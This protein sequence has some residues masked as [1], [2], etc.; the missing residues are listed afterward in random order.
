MK[1]QNNK[2]KIL[3]VGSIAIDTI[4]SVHGSINERIQIKNGKLLKQNLMF[5]ANE[6]KEFYGGTGGNIAYG[7]GLLGAKPLLFSVA[8]KDFPLVYEK[9]LKKN[10]VVSKVLVLKNHWT[11]NFYG[12]TDNKLEQ[13]GIWQPNAYEHLEQSSLLDTCSKKELGQVS[14]AI[15]SAGTPRSMFKHMIELKENAPSVTIIFD[16]GQLVMTYPKRVLETCL[17]LAS[18]IIVNEVEYKQAGAVLKKTLDE[19]CLKYSKTLIVTKGS[20][21]STIFSPVEKI[22]IPATKVRKV[23]DPTGAGDAYRAGLI[24]ALITGKTIKEACMLG[25]RIASKSIESDGPQTY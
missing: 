8:G 17:S 11:A 19:V 2:S 12:I 5:A 10:G 16:P 9:H 3:V 24:S 7:L 23:I 25:A 21:G 13:I 4:F 14:I 1:S 20:A 15:F 22:M 18:I 6:K